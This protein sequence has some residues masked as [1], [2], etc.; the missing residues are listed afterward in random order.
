MNSRAVDE[1]RAYANAVIR[2]CLSDSSFDLDE[3]L[4]KWLLRPQPSLGGRTA[5]DTLNESDGVEMVK[6]MLGAM[7]SGAYL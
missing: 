7:V 2:P 5:Y 3:W 1:I 4:D 6:R